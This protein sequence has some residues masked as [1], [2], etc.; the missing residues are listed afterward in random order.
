MSWETSPFPFL[1]LTHSLARSSSDCLVTP[2][3]ITPS[4]GG[5]TSSFSTNTWKCQMHSN[6]PPAEGDNH[7]SWNTKWI[8]ANILPNYPAGHTAQI[9]RTWLNHTILSEKWTRSYIYTV[10][11]FF[12]SVVPYHLLMTFFIPSWLSN[13]DFLKSLDRDYTNKTIISN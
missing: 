7:S 13:K 1:F 2:G 12:L 4:S 9:P 8:N 3:R 5:V 6:L 10:I 11:F